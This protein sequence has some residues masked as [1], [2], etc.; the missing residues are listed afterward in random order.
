MMST[1][2]EDAKALEQPVKPLQM[3]KL[4]WS[5]EPQKNPKLDTEK[6]HSDTEAESSS[7]TTRSVRKTTRKKA[8][9]TA[10]SKKNGQAVSQVARLDVTTYMHP[11]ANNTSTDI[12]STPDL[13]SPKDF[14]FMNLNDFAA[15]ETA[16]SLDLVPVL[17][18]QEPVAPIELPDAI[19]TAG[20]T[21]SITCFPQPAI[22]SVSPIPAELEAHVKVGVDPESENDTFLNPGDFLAVSTPLLTGFRDNTEEPSTSDDEDA[23]LLSKRDKYVKQ[24]PWNM[25]Q[26]FTPARKLFHNVYHLSPFVTATPAIQPFLEVNVPPAEVPIMVTDSTA[27]LVETE[28]ATAMKSVTIAPERLSWLPNINTP[29]IESLLLL[30]SQNDIAS[31]SRF[32]KLL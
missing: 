28:L 15:A 26:Y 27:K 20:D 5:A 21:N 32:I 16:D 7:P 30:C 25:F 19:G 24:K 6:K 18:G 13:K 31:F 9:K 12:P 1:V 8:P 4:V 29:S 3:P 22:E 10:K 2:D 11:Q 17:P 14:T 23:T